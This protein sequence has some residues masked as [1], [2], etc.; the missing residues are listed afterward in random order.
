MNFPLDEIEELKRSFV[1]LSTASEGGT[2][3]IL[4][5]EMSLPAGCQ[6]GVV[7]ALFCPSPRD[8]YTSRLFLS[9]RVAH[10]GKGQNWN[11]G[12]GVMIL[13]RQWWAVSWK[14][15][16]S[17]KRLSAILASQLEAFK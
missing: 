14:A 8:G 3:F 1:G 6:P 11:P 5:P 10:H 9:A 2:A 7:D 15:Q 16:D 12:T 17:N 13:G 4:I